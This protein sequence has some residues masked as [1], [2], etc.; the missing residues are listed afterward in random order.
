MVQEF[1]NTVNIPPPLPFPPNS[2]NPSMS[3]K[4][5]CEDEEKWRHLMGNHHELCDLEKCLG[6]RINGLFI[7]QF[8]NIPGHLYSQYLRH[9]RRQGAYK[10]KPCRNFYGPNR[11]C[12]TGDLCSF[13]HEMDE[14]R[15]L[16]HQPTT[17]NF[18]MNNDRDNTDPSMHP[19]AFESIKEEHASVMFGNNNEQQ[20]QTLNNLI[21]LV[22]ETY[23]RM[24][25]QVISS[26]DYLLSMKNAHQM[27]QKSKHWPFNLPLVTADRMVFERN[28]AAAYQT[29]KKDPCWEDCSTTTES[30]RSLS[31]TAPPVIRK[32]VTYT[33]PLDSVDGA[34]SPR[35]S[36]RFQSHQSG[37][38]FA[39]SFH[40]FGESYPFKNL[41]K[42]N[43]SGTESSGTVEILT[44]IDAQFHGRITSRGKYQNGVFNRAL[45]LFI[46]FLVYIILLHQAILDSIHFF[47]PDDMKRQ[48]E[49][50]EHHQGRMS[51]GTK[52]Y[53]T[54]GYNDALAEGKFELRLLIPTKSA[55]AVIGKGGESIKSL[56]AKY[57]A[58]VTVPDR[59]TPERILTIVCAQE[60]LADC[61][62]EILEKL[63]EDQGRDDVDIRVIVHQSHA[64]AIIGKQGS[65]IKE[66]RE[67]MQ[68]QIK[69]FQECA[70]QSTD[71]VVLIT[72]Q[73]T[74]MPDAIKHLME[75]MREVPIKGPTKP[76]DPSS[77]DPRIVQCYG[78]FSGPM[79]PPPMGGP[80]M[81]GMHGGG[82]FG[83]RGP[84]GVPA[85]MG[86][87][88]GFMQEQVTTTQ[89]TIPNELGGT[90]I[91]K[92]GDRINRIRAESGARIEIGN[93]Y[94][95][96]ER[97]ITITGTPHQ[98]QSA[99]YLLQQSVRTSEAG[100]R[101]LR[102]QC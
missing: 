3:S 88:G 53:R 38:E 77:H 72:T 45:L 63:A 12:P 36:N 52:R 14:K 1:N 94:G 102:E 22:T 82:G 54:D 28:C 30:S 16:L 73:Q 7:C 65:K 74:K 61:F 9:R 76:Y 44:E 2:P 75:F 24:C 95:N 90:I 13:F 33:L 91:G 41:T 25:K 66:L 62:S 57:D 87:P 80:P 99:Q 70:P 19:F 29:K 97:I 85:G 81:G 47:V 15:E 100:R 31:P 64:G 27:Q 5:N 58:I 46:I 86:M 78:G 39:K 71:R 8:S 4:S 43:P 56:R 21:L 51:S 42:G 37:A 59:S 83:P 79:P 10:T 11:F 23:Q 20:Q 50:M 26:D 84:P 92:G 101:Y 89:V 68:A 48:L 60:K 55:G 6:K 18:V 32:L 35:I 98:I 40:P 34:E 96:E 17:T 67:L 93:A 49:P 69:V